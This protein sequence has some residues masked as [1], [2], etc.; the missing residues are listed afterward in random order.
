MHS[1]ES[2][3]SSAA[4][5]D[6]EYGEIQKLLPTCHRI[7]ELPGNRLHCFHHNEM[8]RNQTWSSV[9]EKANVSNLGE[10]L[11]EGNKDHLLNPARTEIARREIHVE[12]LNKCIN[13][14][15]KGGTRQDITRSAKRS[16]R[17]SLRTNWIARGILRKKKTL[18]D[19]QIKCMHELGRMKAKEQQVA[20]FSVQKSRESRE[21]VEQLTYQ[22]QSM[23]DDDYERFWKISDC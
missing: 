10:T 9:F 15:Q 14:S 16:C 6:L 19:A 3:E 17:I 4:D 11:F 22:L 7:R 2:I 20:E 21:T 13:D 8:K 1:D 12:S 18:R 5:P 23:Q